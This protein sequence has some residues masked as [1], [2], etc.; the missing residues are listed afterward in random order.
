MQTDDLLPRLNPHPSTPN[1]VAMSSDGHILLSASSAP[2]TVLIQDRRRAGLAAIEFKPADTS[3]AVTC[4]AFETHPGTREPS[5]TQ[6][7]LGH[8]DGSLALYKIL[9][10]PLSQSEFSPHGSLSTDRQLRPVAIGVM[11]KLHKAAMGGVSAAAFIPGF[12]SRVVSIGHDGR[13]RLT[14]FASGGQMLRT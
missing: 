10:A 3:S 12:A 6:F 13:C 5:H 14:D 9:M 4:A 11:S 7:V 8:K 1:I 2:P